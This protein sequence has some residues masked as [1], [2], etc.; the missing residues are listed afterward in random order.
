MTKAARSRITLRPNDLQIAIEPEEDAPSA[1]IIISE[2]WQ[3]GPDT[4]ED[5][6]GAFV[7]C[8]IGEFDTGE[9]LI[10]EAKR[11]QFFARLTSWRDDGARIAIYFQTEGEIERF[12]E[13]LGEAQMDASGLELV[14]GTLARGFCFPAANLVVLAAAEI[15]GRAPTHGRRRLQRASKFG[16]QRAQIDFSELHEDDLVVHL[17]HGIGR[18]LGPA[19]TRRRGRERSA[20]DRVRRR[21]ETLR[22]ARAG[23]HGFPLRRRR[24]KIA[25]AQLAGRREMGSRAEKRRGFRLR[26]RRQNARAP[27]RARDADSATL[28]DPIR[29]GRASSSTRFRFAK[30]PIN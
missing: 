19:K 17:E 21:S 2:N 11:Q 28:S 9:F 1:A 24:E 16:A 7:D 10:A 15:F 3:G 25:A 6:S 29:N 5:F 30:R 8:E 23:V 12:R 20:R 14:E 18:F 4:E 22:P 13:I 27:S 26:L